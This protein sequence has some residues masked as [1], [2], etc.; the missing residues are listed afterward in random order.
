MRW[1]GRRQS[2]NVEDRRGIPAGGAVAG[3]GGVVGLIVVAL[4]WALGGD[5]KPVMD[6]VQA[7]GGAGGAPAQRGEA[8]STGE[9]D[10]TTDFVQVVLA[11]TEDV[12]NQQFRDVLGEQ[13]P[14]PT[15]V[16]FSGRVRSGCGFASAQ[17]G[18]FYC[19]ADSKVYLDTSFFEQLR[20]QL[21]APGDFASAYVIAHEVGHHVQNVLGQM[22]QV[23]RARR[24]GNEDA[25]NR[26]SV[27]LELQAD[28]LAGVWAH[29][30]QR[31]NNILEPGDIEEALTAA[32]AI[33]DDTLQREATGTVMPDSFTHGTS[34][35]R[36]RWFKRGFQTGD[37]RL[38]QELFARDYGEL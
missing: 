9:D 34:A 1:R 16:L 3:G 22:D 4:V 20:S 30:A 38:M 14:V 37:L 21:D 28:F 13:Y 23:D 8:A 12:W 25:A 32:N 2:G 36:V 26:A 33:G 24:S 17:V 11:D 18:P 15:L 6:A 10:P 27:R 5:P 19:P 35:Q 31:M 7:G 29:H